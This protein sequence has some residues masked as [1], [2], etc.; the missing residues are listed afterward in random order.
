MGSILTCERVIKQILLFFS[1]CDA[2]IAALLTVTD[3]LAAMSV[4]LSHIR[5]WKAFFSGTRVGILS[6]EEVRGLF[7]ELLFLRHLYCSWLSQ[8]EAIDAWCGADHVQQDFI[9]RDTAVEV[10]SLTGKERNSV[11]IS[12]EDQLETL[13]SRLFLRVYRLTDFPDALL[14]RSLNNLVSLI[15]GELTDAYTV[16]KFTSKLAAIGYAPLREYEVPVFVVSTEKT[17]KVIE[18]F[19]KLV[20]SAL[21]SGIARLSY[22]L[23]LESL[24]RYECVGEIIMEELDGSDD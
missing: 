3:S 17:F 18:D 15:E 5:R 8:H 23:E 16:E 7:A 22:D 10:K 11:R 4:S 6:P 20:R 19:P 13:A 14:G 9:F 1:L 12:S 21:P 24:E 2:L